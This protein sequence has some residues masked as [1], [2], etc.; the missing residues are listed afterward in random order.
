M[1]VLTPVSTYDL[2]FEMTLASAVE[3]FTI[4]NIPQTYTD[5]VLETQH[6]F[7]GGGLDAVARFNGDTGTNYSWQEFV[8]SAS[9]MAYRGSNS[10]YA[11]LDYTTG[12]PTTLTVN[13]TMNIMSYSNTNVYKTTL[14]TNASASSTIEAM[15]NTWR[16]TAAITSITLK[17]SNGGTTF[18]AGSTFRL[19]GIA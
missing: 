8:G 3:N 13:H 14:S 9:A 2:L 18:L 19:W 17:V 1:P 5:L 6:G 11:P 10:A 7:T 16:S 12:V 4:S 15:T